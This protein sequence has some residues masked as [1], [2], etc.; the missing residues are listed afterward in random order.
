M[1]LLEDI[2]TDGF[3]I[4][5]KHSTIYLF[6]NIE[7]KRKYLLRQLEEY[8]NKE[9]IIQWLVD[10]DPVA[11]K[12]KGKK[13]PF[14]NDILSWFLNGKI[15]LPEDIETT[16]EA[17]T[18]YNKAKQ[19]GPV[20]SASEYDSPGQIRREIENNVTNLNYDVA[21][22]VDQDGEFKMYR[23]DDYDTQGKICFE[24][25]GWCVQH[26]NH[27]LEYGPPFFMITKGKKDMLYCIKKLAL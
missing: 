14:V 10:A 3:D 13:T 6:E 21:E 4:V 19:D 25:S 1:I 17:L 22:L 7:K 5:P 11:V 24:N 20:K 9:E 16:K 2:L 18:I 15:I 27:F 12:S 23:I 8:E 26:K